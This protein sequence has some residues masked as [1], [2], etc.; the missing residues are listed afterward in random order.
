MDMDSD[1][2]IRNHFY[3]QGGSM[4]SVLL[5]NGGLVLTRFCVRRESPKPANGTTVEVSSVFAVVNPPFFESFEFFASPGNPDYLIE[6]SL[7][8][9]QMRHSLIQYAPIPIT[10]I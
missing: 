7:H 3:P 8:K 10:E 9:L 4:R 2:S 5:Q 6:R 1:V